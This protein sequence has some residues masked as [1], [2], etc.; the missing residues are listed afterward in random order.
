[1]SWGLKGPEETGCTKPSVLAQYASRAVISHWAKEFGQV[2]DDFGGT[3]HES[4]VGCLTVGLLVLALLSSSLW[5]VF[6]RSFSNCFG[7]PLP[8][9]QTLWHEFCTTC[10]PSSQS[11]GQECY[12]PLCLLTRPT[13]PLQ[14]DTLRRD[15]KRS[16]LSPVRGVT[17]SSNLCGISCSCW[18]CVSPVTREV[19]WHCWGLSGC[20]ESYR[21]SCRVQLHQCSNKSIN[22]FACRSRM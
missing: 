9:L 19:C 11:G 8:S 22:S 5:T 12:F 17:G 21:H 15:S 20:G 3:L 16:F 7:F 2:G 1:M 18:T 14:G 4:S 6:C 10:T 13:F